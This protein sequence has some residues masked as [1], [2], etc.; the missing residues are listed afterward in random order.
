[1]GAYRSQLVGQFLGETALLV[2]VALILGLGLA[3]LGLPRVAA[4]M[5]IRVDAG[6]LAQPGVVAITALVTVAVI[7]LAGLYPSFVQSAFRPVES[8]KSRPRVSLRG[9]SLRKSLVVVQ[10]ALSQALLFGTLVV[11]RQMDFF[12][13]QELGFLKEAVITFGVPDKAKREVLA[14]Q[15]AAAPGVEDVT[16]S[17]GAPIHTYSATSLSAPDLGITKEQVTQWKFVD[18]HY[19]DMFGLKL[20]AGR[21][22]GK[23]SEKDTI[24][25]VVVNRTLLH[26]LG[27]PTPQE[28]LG[29]RIMVNGNP[30]TYIVGVVE[31]FQVGSKHGLL[32]PCV[33]QYRP[34]A[35]FMASAKIHPGRMRETIGRIDQTWS[36]L[37]PDHLFSYKFI[38]DHIAELYRQ[39]QKVY[40]AFQ[41]FCAIALVIG[42]LGL[43]GLVSFM[44][45][46]R[47][48][49]VGVRKVLGASVGHIL[50]L[51]TRE[52]IGLVLVS[53][54][55]AAP[56]GIYVANQWLSG[57]AY[58][59]AL[60]PALCLLAVGFTLTVALLTVSYQSVKAALANPARSLR[61]E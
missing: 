57:F 49:E 46:Q 59:I 35:F 12:R 43:Y 51:F 27:I 24:P 18:E 32:G 34:D 10:F 36:S 61:S 1:L 13:N 41:I 53:F 5:D 47:T 29:K 11:A 20:L 45:V 40:T 33:L 6:Q 9:V 58:R 22:I 16:F 44:T 38:D 39:E 7:L 19:L 30:H 52:Y 21:K 42:C 50:L 23:V 55:V 31:D 54:V 15:L 60:T 37:F 4:W 48:K 26:K 56:V 25:H 2:G 8:L 3:V 17:S 14:Q 28:A